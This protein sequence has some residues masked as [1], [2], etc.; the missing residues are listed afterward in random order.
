MTSPKSIVCLLL[1]VGLVS[2]FNV[3][4]YLYPTEENVTVSYTDFTLRGHDYSLVALD[5]E[6][7]FLLKHEEVVTNQSEIESVLYSYYLQMHYPSEE[8]IQDLKDL[9]ERFN[10]SRNDGYDWPNKEEYVCRDDVMLSNGKVTHLGE[11]LVCRDEESCERIGMLLFSAYG[12]G[13]GLGSPT[14]LIEAVSEFTPYS[15]EM[16]D[17]VSNYTFMLENLNEN[18]LEETMDYIGDTVDTLSTNSEKIEDTIFRTPRLNDTEDR[19]ACYLK[20]YAICP[21]FDLDQDALGEIDDMAED[22]LSK[23]GPLAGYEEAASNVYNNSMSRIEYTETEKKAEEYSGLFS[24]LNATAGKVISLG[25]EAVL[26]VANSTL[27]G[28][29]FSLKSLH[30]TIPEDIEERNFETME[31]DMLRYD[32][33]IKEVDQGASFLLEQYDE[34]KE[35]KNLANSLIF[36]LESKDLDPVSM[37][38]L[39]LLRNDTADLD[40]EFRDGLTPEELA[41]LESDYTDLARDAQNLLLSEN[42]MPANR[43]LLLFRGYAS[44][45]NTGI[46]SVAEKTDAMEAREIP[47][48]LTLALFSALVFFSLASIVALAFLYLVATAKFVVPKTGYIMASAFV[49]LMVLLLGFSVFM[50]LFLGKTSTDAT[51]P[52]FLADFNSKESTSI[53]VDLRDTSYSDSQAMGSCASSLADSFTQRNKSWTMYSVTAN[54]CTKRDSTGSN[55]TLS[56]DDCLG[57]AENETSLFALEY[58]ASNEPPKFSVIYENKAEIRANLDYYE[59]CPLIAL[60]S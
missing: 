32:E 52:E 2:A 46:A 20:C 41:A 23:I 15:L 24:S 16:D 54:T 1:L 36:V 27:S 5:G 50:Y 28:K 14:P 4:D 26:H 6:D 56:V 55:A 29:L 44:K 22:L 42:D 57:R 9:V 45:V 59:S 40:A 39:E 34:T 11:P 25:D 3:A 51:L 47:E 35:A 12:Q 7:T 53:V 31:E 19:D 37:K 13:L 10:D 21:S 48:N 30:Q 18:T 8:E 33:L 38:A 58:S 49:V 17:I 43:V 60:F